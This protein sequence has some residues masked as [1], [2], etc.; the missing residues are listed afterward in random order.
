WNASARAVYTVNQYWLAEGTFGF[1]KRRGEIEAF[2]RVR[3]LNRL[4]YY[5]SGPASS[6]GNRTSYSYRDPVIGAHAGVKATPWL[7][8]GGRVEQLWPRATA[9]Q[10][11]PSIDQVFS[12]S[13]VS[14]LFARPRFGRYQGSVEVRIP[15]AVG[16][17]FYQGTR[18]R[19]TYA[20]YDDQTLEQ[21]NFHRLD[22]EAQ[23]QFAGFGAWHRLTLSGW[24]STS[25]TDA[26]QDVPFYLQNTLG[27]RS[28]IRSVNE[29]RFGT[30]GTDATLRGFRSL[31]F[32]DRHLLLMQAEYRMPIWGPIEATLFADA[33][34]VA[35]V[36]SDLD[37]TNLR[38]D[39]GFSVS[40]MQ[41]WST[42][43]RVDVA[44]GSGEGARI[45]LSLGGLTP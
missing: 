1:R 22:L 43:A 24:L 39:F 4:D 38:R 17:R 40:A 16:D 6:L 13:E 30:D 11:A 32:R 27:G 25:T 10:R 35:P 12:A 37:F 45:H 34:K 42:V 36:R 31:R 5:G 44:F 23:Q 26:D 29:H 28:A 18:A 15:G 33:G 19:T 41:S 21:F 14:G 9:G 7:T 8:F 20:I 3:E 2:G